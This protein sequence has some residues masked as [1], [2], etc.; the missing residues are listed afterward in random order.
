MSES[1]AVDLEDSSEASARSWQERGHEDDA[2]VLADIMNE[3]EDDG[4]EFEEDDGEGDHS[5]TDKLKTA[6][7]ASVEPAQNSRPASNG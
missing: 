5:A 6:K 4:Q 2:N 1:P 7:S 3:G